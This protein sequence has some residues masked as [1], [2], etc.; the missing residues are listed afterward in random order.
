MDNDSQVPVGDGQG[1]AKGEEMTETLDGLELGVNADA[2]LKI[3]R[4]H[5]SWKEMRIAGDVKV[6]TLIYGIPHRKLI[7]LIVPAGRQRGA[8]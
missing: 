7:R 1:D 4:K 8:Q 6:G 2:A 5:T 3:L